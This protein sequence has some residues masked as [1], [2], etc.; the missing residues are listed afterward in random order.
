MELIYI[1]KGI[2]GNE[3]VINPFGKVNKRLFVYLG[4]E[5]FY[6]YNADNMKLIQE[7]KFEEPS[8]YKNVI[9]GKDN[10]LF[11]SLYNRD[12][13]ETKILEYKYF[14][15]EKKLKRKG[16]R[17]LSL[18]KCNCLFSNNEKG[19]KYLIAFNHEGQLCFLK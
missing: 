3:N 19:K 7:I 4:L 8:L 1:I 2:E 14:P 10:S 9:F 18:G 17:I 12:N 15:K 6:L 5:N 13:G 11:I 16:E